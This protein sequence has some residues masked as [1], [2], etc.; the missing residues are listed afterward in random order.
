MRSGR[1]FLP[2]SLVERVLG[3]EIAV[4][5]H[6]GE[7]DHALELHFAPLAAAGRLAERLDERGGFALEAELA[8][9]ERADLFLEFGVGSFAEFLDLADAEFEFPERVGDRFDEVFDGG[10]A[11]LDIAPG[12]LGVGGERGFRELEELLGGRLEGVGGEGLEGVGELGFGAFEQRLFLGGG[13]EFG[14]E[15][16]AEFGELVAEGLGV[17]L[18]ALGLGGRLG[19]AGLDFRGAA[20]L[21]LQPLDRRRRFSRGGEAGEEPADEEARRRRKR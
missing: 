5:L 17:L 1:S 4:F 13:L 20:L 7:F 15:A 14:V 2:S 9:A 12:L 19:E 21:G 8:F 10:L 16:G 18:V 6:A 3:F 11:F